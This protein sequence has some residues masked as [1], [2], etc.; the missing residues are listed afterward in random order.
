MADKV[1]IPGVVLAGGLSSRMGQDKARIRFGGV[2]LLDHA[3]RYLRPQ[4][5]TIAINANGPVL[6]KESEGL[7]IFPDLD[8]S[9]SGPLGGVAAALDYARRHNPAA[10]HVATVPTDSPFFPGDLVS[11]LHDAVDTPDRIVVARSADGV[12]PVFA[13]WP[14]ALA[15]DL[16]AWL[17][18]SAVLR[19]RSFLDRHGAREVA[20]QPVETSIGLLDPFFNINTPADLE[21]AERW[22][23]V[24][25]R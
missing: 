24:L 2:S 11:R 14:V 7:A 10:R 9:R 20:F 22:L 6:S 8:A 25:Q 16:A 1:P 15:D 3:I 19:V 17:A 21:A 5:S 4:V 13:L 18:S 23:E 12:H